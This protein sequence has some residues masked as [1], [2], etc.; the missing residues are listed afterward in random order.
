MKIKGPVFKS[1][2]AGTVPHDVVEGMEDSSNMQTAT[3]YIFNLF[4]N[5]MKEPTGY[6]NKYED[7]ILTFNNLTRTVSI[8]PKTTSFDYYIKGK[9]YTVTTTHSI[10]ITD[11]EG[12]WYFYWVGDV[13]TCSQTAWKLSN[14]IVP[15]A[16]AYWDSTNKIFITENEERHGV[17]MDFETHSYHHRTD[18]AK[19]D[20][21]YPPGLQIV[22]FND[23]G[24]GSLN[25]HAQY[26]TTDG[27]FFDED[28]I[29]DIRNANP[30]LNNFEQVLY[31]V[32]RL[33]VFYLTGL[34]MWRKKEATDFPFYE[35]PP[36][37]PY[38]NRYL[39][40]LWSLQPV[41]SGFFFATWHVYTDDVTEPVIVLLGQR[42]DSNLINAVNNNTRSNL[43]LPRKFSEEFYFFKKIIWEVSTSFT[44]TP[45][46]RLRYIAQNTETNAANDR[47]AC[48]C[49]YNG[50]A[51]TGRYLEFYSGQSS[52]NSPFPIPE[53][54][55]LKT[56]VLSAVANST[57]SVSI[58]RVSNLSIPLATISL[59][60]SRYLKLE[61][62]VELNTD[63][64]L[65]AKISSG[66]VN[67]PA[68]T[69]FI[70]TNL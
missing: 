39:N 66:S 17:T 11:S 49:N 52:L 64:Q 6:V 19:I 32:S 50:N 63:D 2:V 28:I 61:T 68:V 47:Y 18:G 8:A 1:P 41:T 3:D 44:N 48:I 10:Q 67:K 13:F 34:D 35:N 23:L 29:I 4:R 7:S 15:T 43:Q 24:N 14:P 53:P 36:A 16:T 30:P 12:M 37:L 45:K 40:G 62:A 38:Y 21:S 5:V 27:T 60:N 59:S 70:Q 54:S 20:I 69:I 65:V 42:E 46:C 55:F 58:Y 33:P 9:L 57:G 56:I 22:N 25:S 26:G 51:N 31:P